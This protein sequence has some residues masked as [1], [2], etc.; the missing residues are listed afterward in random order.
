MRMLP[1][2]ILFAMAAAPAASV[3]ADR[4]LRGQFLYQSRCTSCHSIGWQK[5]IEHSGGENGAE[6][7]RVDLT[8]VT[9]RRDDQRLKSF[10]GDPRR[11][12]EGS[13]CRHA[14][15]TREQVDDLVH[16]L[17]ARALPPPPKPKVLPRSQ[18]PRVTSTQ[19]KK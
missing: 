17:H 16:F 8:R 14:A 9:D 12:T 11:E 19:S 13:P 1:L 6:K 18:S 7:S 10:L 3:R 15:L 4:L 5:P 2:A